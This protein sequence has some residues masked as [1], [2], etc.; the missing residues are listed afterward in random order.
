MRDIL[1]NF[2]QYFEMIPAL[3]DEL[4]EEVYKLR[5][6]VYCN[7]T[8]F[9][10]P[11]LC[12]KNMEHDEYDDN[13]IHYLIKHRTSKSYAATTRLIMPDDDNIDKLL[14]IEQHTCIEDYEIL[15]GIPRE[16]IAEV[17][18]FC[19]S[20]KF[21]RRI[22][23][24]TGI[25]TEEPKEVSLKEKITFPHIT[26]ALIACLIKASDEQHITYWF[27]IMEPALLRFLSIVGIRFTDIGPVI[28][29][30]GKRKPCVIKISDLLD[31][32]LQKN[33]SLWNMLTDNGRVGT[34][35]SR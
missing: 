17:S 15:K 6:Q 31:G 13:S 33:E 27:A 34:K 23:F 7:E 25:G 24:L 19:V 5:F 8:G 29:Y 16:N 10:D 4:K 1:D 2:N 21:K 12:P 30:H 9:E 32:V 28:E 3:S 22:N 20:N 11:A 26:L 35:L 14:P 18:R